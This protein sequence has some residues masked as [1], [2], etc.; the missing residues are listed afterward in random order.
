MTTQPTM[1]DGLFVVAFQGESGREHRG[2]IGFRHPIAES[3]RRQAMKESSCPMLEFYLVR[4]DG[5]ETAAKK[6]KV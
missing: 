5:G 4:V 2:E 3:L 1:P 6:V